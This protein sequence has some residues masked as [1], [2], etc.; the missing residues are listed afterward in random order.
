[1]FF[2]FSRVVAA[3]FCAAALAPA[4][5]ARA[6]DAVLMID[7]EFSFVGSTSAQA[8]ELGARIAEREIAEARYLPGVNLIVRTSDNRGIA[9]RGADNFE[10][11]AADPTVMAVMGGK[12]S[13]VLLEVVPRATERKLMLLVPW[14]AADAI[15]D[16]GTKP[17]WVFRIGLKDEWATEALAA[18][19]LRRGLR[20]VGAILVSTAWG[21]STYTALNRSARQLG[22]RLVGERWHNRGET[23]FLEKYRDLRS[24]GAQA[25]ILAGNET[26]GGLLARAIASLPEGERVPVLAHWGV[27]GGNLVEIAGDALA[28]VDLSVVQTFSFARQRTRKA[29]RL[30]RDVLKATGKS[31]SAAIDS[32]VGIAHAYDLTWML[33]RAIKQA[34]VLDRGRVRDEMEKLG[35]FEGV[36]KHYD[37][38][39]TEERHEALSKRDLFFSRYKP[40]VGLTP[41]D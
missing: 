39:F 2:L 19:A 41:V 26:E 13:P 6:A 38:P 16:N 27:A 32:Q 11:A 12:Y 22:V 8:I 36:V 35:P 14:G 3:A 33:A 29:E 9:A 10:D 1:M 40:G 21:R 28:S 30:E 37:R 15:V 5:A 23:D 4:A 18:A 34:G 7:A 25:I 24:R 17:N 31:T 20:D